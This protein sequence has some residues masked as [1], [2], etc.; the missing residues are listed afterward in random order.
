LLCLQFFSF[1]KAAG[2]SWIVGKFGHPFVMKLIISL[3]D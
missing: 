1:C 3:Y 2:I